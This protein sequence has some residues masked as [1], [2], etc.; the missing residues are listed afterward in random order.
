MNLEKC[1]VTFSTNDNYLKLSEI[2][3][4][5]VSKFSKYPIIL[6]CI[7]FDEPYFKDKFSNVFYKKIDRK[8]N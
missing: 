5:S 1:F 6:Y 7:D 8:D 4:E 2:M 3:I